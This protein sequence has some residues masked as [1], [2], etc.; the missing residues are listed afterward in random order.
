MS[1]KTNFRCD[2]CGHAICK[3]HQEYYMTK[4]TI[5]HRTNTDGCGE[6]DDITDVYHVHNDLG[7]YCMRKLWDILEKHRK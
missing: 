1:E 3:G 6:T 7:N 5:D 4:V 2:V